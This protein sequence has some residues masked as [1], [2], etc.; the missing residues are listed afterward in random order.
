MKTNYDTGPDNNS[1]FLKVDV[2]TVGV[3]HTTVNQY[4]KGN[5]RKFIVGSSDISGD[6]PNQVIGLSQNLRN[7]FL[8]VNIMIDF[9]TVGAD[10]QAQAI[11]NTL[12]NFELAGASSASIGFNPDPDD[13]HFS[14]DKTIMSVLKQIQMS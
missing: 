8:M 5:P 12:I 7:S 3:A 4:S 2:G 14:A 6:I 1:I 10:S 9:S 13:I 11:A